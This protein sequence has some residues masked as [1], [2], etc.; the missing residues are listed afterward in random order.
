MQQIKQL[1]RAN[2]TGEEVV[3]S[4]TYKNADWTVEKQWIPSG[5]V[6]NNNERDAALVVGGGNTWQAPKGGFDLKYVKRPKA[7]SRL[8]TY[9]TNGVYK[10][11]EP[12]F[13]VVDDDA[14]QEVAQSG[15]CESHIVYAHA[16]VILQYPGKLYLIP[17]D[18]SW[19]AGA[20]ATYMACFDG[21]KKIY[22]MGFDGEQGNDAF[23]ERAMLQ[24]FNLYNE[25]EFV[26][27]AP[28]ANYYM[29]ESWKYCVNL[30]QIT[31]RNFVI[32]AD[33]WKHWLHSL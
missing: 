31:F 11:F 18:P 6:D 4:L 16:E 23:Y 17:Q 12:D 3:T 32:E 29:P 22:L 30:R 9:A 25:V 8:K 21:H 7:A 10:K 2:Y 5:V 27:V 14:A 26:R 13:L 19:N 15:Y 24:L 20:V 28:T 1:Y 33:L